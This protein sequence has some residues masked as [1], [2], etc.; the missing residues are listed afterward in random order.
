MFDLEAAKTALLDVS[1]TLIVLLIATLVIE[2]FLYVVLVRWRRSRLALPMMLLAPGVAAVLVLYGY[3]LLYEFN[4]S[5][6]KMNIRNFVEPGL[7]GLTWQGTI[8]EGTR[9]SAE[10][11]I[12]VGLQNYIDVFTKPVL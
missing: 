12:F 11:D 3:P 8:L 2:V 10:R 5:F 9:F 4:I 6:T 7:L 1:T